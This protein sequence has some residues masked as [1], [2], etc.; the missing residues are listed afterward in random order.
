MAQH[1]WSYI[2]HSGKQYIVGVFH[3]AKTGHLLIYIN[4]KIV[5]IDFKVLEDAMYSFFIDDELCEVSIKK[6]NGGYAY[7][8]R[9]NR[10]VD[11]PLNRHLN[12]FDRVN[13]N[14]IIAMLV[15]LVIFVSL[16]LAYGNYQKKKKERENQMQLQE[17]LTHKSVSIMGVIDS[18]IWAG[19]NA[20]FY[21]TFQDE[22]VLRS[23]KSA[24]DKSRFNLYTQGIPILQGDEF[25]V[26]YNAYRDSAWL[27]LNEPS[28][29]QLANFMFRAFEKEKQFNP[30][31][32]DRELK[33][34][35]R[36][37]FEVNGLSGLA[38]FYF[39]DQPQKENPWHNALTYQNLVRDLPF[40]QAFVQYCQ[41][42]RE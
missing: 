42:V 7:D 34:R 40:Q 3:G 14:R 8:F 1:K 13:R 28:D 2:S 27:L 37:A 12:A 32:S 6:K 24:I 39:Q 4:S 11:T 17:L 10:E 26:K 21:Y 18:V 16:A 20:C 36:C 33:C 15:G 41:P 5:Q 35:V 9:V 31:L 22:E 25:M 38:D 23:A 29:S 19:D 30:Q